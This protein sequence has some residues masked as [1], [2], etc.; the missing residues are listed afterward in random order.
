MKNQY[1]S[2]LSI[3]KNLGSAKSGLGHWLKQRFTAIMLALFT[4]W[5]IRFAYNLAHSETQLAFIGVLKVPCNIVMLVLFMMTALYHGVLGMNVI[6]ED[7]IHCRAMKISALLLLK[8][9][10][11]VSAAGFIVSLIY[12]INL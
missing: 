5:L 11:I 6:I 3:A 1:R 12:V 7:Y 9:F 8:I 4:I 2:S 10:S